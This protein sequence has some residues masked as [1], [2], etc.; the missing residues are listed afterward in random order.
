M[1]RRLLAALAIL[2]LGPGTTL[3]VPRA[4]GPDP[5]VNTATVLC[6]PPSGPC[7]PTDVVLTANVEVAGGACGFDL[8][9][10]ALRVERS[11]QVGRGTIEMQNA[12][13][14]TITKSGSLKAR[15]DFVQPDGHI[16][17]GGSVTLF[18][19]GGVTIA[20]TVDVSGDPAGIVRLGAFGDVTVENGAVVRG[21]GITSF[22]SEGDRMAD[23]GQLEV[24]SDDGTIALGGDVTFVGTQ[25]GWGGG[26][27]LLASRDVRITRRIDASGGEG[28][29]IWIENGDSTAVAAPL[30]AESRGGGGFGGFITVVA[31][32][33]AL[34]GTAVGGDLVVD[35]AVLRVDASSGEGFG[36]DGGE[37]FLGA[38]GDVAVG[39]TGASLRANAGTNFDGVG[40]TVS[41]EARG[42]VMLGAPVVARSGSAGGDGGALEAYADGALAVTAAVDLAGRGGGGDVFAGAGSDVTLASV[43][44]VR[45]TGSSARGGS[46]S[47]RAGT[48]EHGTLALLANVLAT[49]GAASTRGGFVTLAGCGLDVAP[50]VR[51]D[52]RTGGPS[53]GARMQLVARDP[54]RLGAGSQYLATPL[55]RI[56]TTHPPGADP[57]IGRNVVFNPARIDDAS[58]FGPYPG[59]G[60]P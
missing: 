53:G 7:T 54:M 51:I 27:Y 11:L 22:V 30:I 17:E 33:D 39:G 25:R 57:V 58:G 35:G 12:A 49:G 4:C 48:T 60:L 20:G 32:D 50:G 18:A 43:L 3:A 9:G 15:G 14:I 52:G 23:G 36:G 47:V 38:Y 29:E 16:L 2:I 46:V 56:V 40:G 26:V 55:G 24:V 10:R 41:L 8:G 28:G 42:S 44:D 5:V 45:G 6:A 13:A 1:T 37:I 21:D 31:G 34:G 19:A 59:C